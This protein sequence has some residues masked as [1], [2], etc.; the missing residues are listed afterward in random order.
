MSVKWQCAMIYIDEV[1]VFSQSPE[2]HVMHIKEVLGL[3]MASGMALKL[4]TCHFISKSV[5]V[6]KLR[7]RLVSPLGLALSRA[8][9][10]Y[11]IDTDASDT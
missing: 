6:N 10:Q 4:K 8:I 1:V 9:G 3:L 11:T 7:D 2:V 5:A